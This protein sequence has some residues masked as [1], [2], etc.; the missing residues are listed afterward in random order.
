MLIFTALS[1]DATEIAAIRG[2]TNI[3]LY[4]RLHVPKGGGETLKTVKL[5]C[6]QIGGN[7]ANMGIPRKL[8]E[9]SD[10]QML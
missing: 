1:I 6:D 3:C 8:R 5:Q 4:Q 9:S 2:K 10:A 7:D